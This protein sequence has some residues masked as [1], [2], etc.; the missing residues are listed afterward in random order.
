MLKKSIVLI[1]A[2]LAISLVLAACTPKKSETAPYDDDKILNGDLSEFAGAWVNG[3]DLIRRLKPNGT[4]FN[5]EIASGFSRQSDQ[6]PYMASGGDYYI[7][8]VEIPDEMGYGVVLY[9]VGVDVYGYNGIIPSDKTKV[10]LILY[11]HDWAPSENSI[12]YRDTAAPPEA[13]TEVEITETQ[14]SRAYFQIVNGTEIYM[15]NGSGGSVVI[16]D[17]ITIIGD[18]AFSN[19]QL[20]SITIPNSVI[21]IGNRAFSYNQLTA[22]TIPG[23]TNISGD[24]FGN[25]PITSITIG[26]NVSLGGELNLVFDEVNPVM[27]WYPAFENEF[28]YFYNSQGKHAGTYTFSGRVW[29]RSGAT[30][31][32]AEADFETEPNDTGLTIRFYQGSVNDLVIPETIGG[33]KVTE[34]YETTKD[35]WLFLGKDLTSVV[36]PDSITRIGRNVF[37]HNRLTSITIPDSITSIGIRAF[38]GNPLT[39][40]TI[41]ANVSLGGEEYDDPTSDY[42]QLVFL[43]AFDNDFDG[44]YNTNGKQGG[45]YTWNGSTW[46]RR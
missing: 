33:I 28:D 30:T 10:R 26:S 3:A 32:T 41:G 14:T 23:V 24:A 21:S 20:T 9:S 46:N 1:F 5:A 11:A 43:P 31:L 44:F 27:A 7:W 12:F 8:G 38:A 17:G 18:K 6:T 16:P 37:L 2:L 45:T 39:S 22:V 4:F 25:N 15:Y 35:W 36:I 40:I 13:Q 42:A 34:L 19:K 29:Q